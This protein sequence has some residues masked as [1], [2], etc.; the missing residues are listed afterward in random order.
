MREAEIFYK[1]KIV[2]VVALDEFMGAKK[3]QVSLVKID[4]EGYEYPVLKGMKLI[5]SASSS[6]PVVIIE[7]VQ[8]AQERCGFSSHDI[9]SWFHQH[10]YVLYNEKSRQKVLSPLA[11]DQL[12]YVAV[13]KE[14]QNIFHLPVKGRERRK[15][16]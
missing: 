6:R 14:K 5:L 2:P 9:F 3:D 7:I 4:V 11:A 1:K 12:N 8:E 16:L 10:D 13:P 15:G